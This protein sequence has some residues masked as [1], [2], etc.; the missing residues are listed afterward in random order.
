[1][2]EEPPK[3]DEP[4]PVAPLAVEDPKEEVR[5]NPLFYLLFIL[6]ILLS[7]GQGCS[8][9]RCHRLNVNKLLV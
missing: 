8:G 5:F 3:I 6:L 4:A 9:C 7:P 1:M 2:T